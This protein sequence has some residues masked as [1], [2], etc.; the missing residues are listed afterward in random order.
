MHC[1]AILFDID[2]T[3]LDFLESSY[4]AMRET[5]ARFGR[6]SFSRDEFREY[7]AVNERLWEQFE[8][9]E[10]EKSQIFTERFRIYFGRIG[11]S[12]DTADFNAFYLRKLA[13]G[14]A[15]MPHCDELLRALYGKYRLFAVTNGD[16]FAQESRL[17]KSGLRQYF[18]GVFISEQFGCKKPEK[19][20]FDC[21]FAQ[22]GEQ[23][24]ACSVIVG[25]SLT[26]DMQGGRNAGIRTCYFGRRE[27]ADG[28]CDD[29]IEDLLELPPLLQSLAEEA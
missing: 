8:R 12:C 21:V 18:D 26:S 15:K 3:L 13:D 20:F 29:V 9:G 28:R 5:F 23:Y 7:A 19:A 16:T 17:Q 11:F 10:I 6:P 27:N 1:R 14:T 24:R 22:I 4:H 2:N 25:D